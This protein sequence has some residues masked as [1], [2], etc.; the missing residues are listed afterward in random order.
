MF[1]SEV[2][3]MFSLYSLYRFTI[4]THKHPYY[5]HT[6]TP[7]TH[8]YTHTHIYLYI[9]Y[10]LSFRLYIIMFVSVVLNKISLYTIY[11]FTIYT[12]KHPYIKT[13]TAVMSVNSL[14]K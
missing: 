9:Q 13:E 3:N 11:A 7:R 14:N 1:V 4:Y 2:R 12:C 8:N 6:Y 10:K 5:T